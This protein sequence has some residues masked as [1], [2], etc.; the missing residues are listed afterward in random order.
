MTDTEIID[1]LQ[2]LVDEHFRLR[3]SMGFDLQVGAMLMTVHR[4][5]PKHDARNGIIGPGD[6]PNLRGLL[7]L[8]LQPHVLRLVTNKLTQR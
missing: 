8:H 3:D 7:A 1:A 4:P 2:A 5:L 6:P